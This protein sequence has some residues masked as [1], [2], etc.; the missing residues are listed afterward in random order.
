MYVST[1]KYNLSKPLSIVS[2]SRLLAFLT[3]FRAICSIT[4][5]HLNR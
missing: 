1:L 4:N 5:F 3:L 2:K